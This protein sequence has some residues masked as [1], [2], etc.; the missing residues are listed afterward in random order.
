MA[1]RCDKE[2]GEIIKNICECAPNLENPTE[3]GLVK[4]WMN[5]LN[6][7]NYSDEA[8]WN[9][10]EYARYL[11]YNVNNNNLHYPFVCTP[12]KEKLQ[13]LED[14]LE[15]KSPG[16]RSKWPIPC[17]ERKKEAK[18]MGKSQSLSS[19]TASIRIYGE[20]QKKDEDDAVDCN[21]M[22]LRRITAEL[23]SHMSLPQF[24][25]LVSPYTCDRGSILR[26]VMG[27]EQ[28][29]F[30]NF[31]ERTFATRTEDVGQLLARDQCA[32]KNQLETWRQIMVN[33]QAQCEASLK[34]I[35][36]DFDWEQYNNNPKYIKDLFIVKK[37]PTCKKQDENFK[38]WRQYMLHK[39]GFM[40]EKLKE[41]IR[42]N[43]EMNQH[44]SDL[45]REHQERQ[46]ENTLNQQM[47]YERNHSL[48]Q[49][50]RDL[51]RRRDFNQQ[52][53]DALFQQIEACKCRTF[54][55]SE[56]DM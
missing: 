27:E 39:I 30:R 15:K 52:K 35:V 31:V 33:K 18:S 23:G 7:E 4:Q 46:T 34:E 56:N 11:E 43:E 16:R 36:P 42:Q 1:D 12:P 48:T 17:S 49:N 40:R 51:R 54:D 19:S 9:R 32:L 45:R 41:V 20:K 6:R 26:K 53:I 25:G 37:E 14:V 50:I 13:P 55:E 47:L 29:T 22:L 38:E 5:K 44:L 10:N 3:Q 2:Y 21:R 24:V 28:V 8:R